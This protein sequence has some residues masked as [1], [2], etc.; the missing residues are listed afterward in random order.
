MSFAC[1]FQTCQKRNARTVTH[2]S[3]VLLNDST[4]VNSA[5][6]RQSVRIFYF[7]VTSFVYFYLFLAFIFF[8]FLDLK[9]KFLNF[10]LL[11]NKDIF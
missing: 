1:I 10:Y 3:H 7:K 5:F 2:P 11:A 4:K 8:E 9:F 6:F